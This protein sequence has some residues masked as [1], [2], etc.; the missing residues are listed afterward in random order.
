MTT[1]TDL[2]QILDK[3]SAT[4]QIT[5][6]DQWVLTCTLYGDG[7]I[8]PAAHQQLQAIHN[9]LTKGFIQLVD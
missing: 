7:D 6:T 8:P 2:L 9:R 5:R 1:M 3:I 4:K